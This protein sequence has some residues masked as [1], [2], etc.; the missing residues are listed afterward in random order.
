MK[1]DRNITKKMVPNPLNLKWKDE[2]QIKERC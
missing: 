1:I 2:E